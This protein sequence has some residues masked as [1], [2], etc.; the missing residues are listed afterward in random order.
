MR[1][2]CTLRQSGQG[3]RF[4]R[5]LR[6]AAPYKGRL[7]VALLAM[8]VYAVGSVGLAALVRRIIDDALQRE[9][10]FEVCDGLLRLSHHSKGRAYVVQS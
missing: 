6:Y 9:R 4:L 7:A 3:R 10:L 2:A 1:A 5:L 8:I